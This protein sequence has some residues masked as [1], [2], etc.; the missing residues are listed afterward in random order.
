MDALQD[1]FTGLSPHNNDTVYRCI[2]DTLLLKVEHNPDS[3]PVEWIFNG[4]S[5]PFPELSFLLPQ[6]DTLTVQYVMNHDFCPDTTTTFIV[7]LP[8]P[9]FTYCHDD[10]LCHGASLSVEQPNVISSL[11]ST[12][13][14]TPAITVDSAGV[15]SV[16]VTNRGCRAESDLFTIDL[17]PQSAVAFGNDSTLCELAT[18]LLDATQPHPASYEWQDQSTNT[19]YT[20]FEDGQY[21]VVVT[22]HCLGASDTIAIGYLTDFTVDL[23]PDTTL[24]EGRTLLLSAEVPFCNYE[25]QN[26]SDRPTF[27]V[28]HPGTYSVTVTNKCFIHGDD[29]VVEYEPCE[30]ELWLP[31]SFT[32]DGD[33]LN[34]VFLPIFAYPDEV[35]S[36]EMTIFD[37]WGMVQY[38]TRRVD[39]GWD[40]AGVPDGVYVVLVRYK[41]RGHAP[42]SVTGNVVKLGN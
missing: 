21:W 9:M 3:V 2:G 1:C 8:P 37:R 15:Y 19:T 20:V 41:T 14:H 23:G 28:Q 13:A 42:Q 25:W 34:D 24:C 31:N 39:Q 7:V 38:S 10:T 12:S 18:L 27:L 5:Y 16:T 4:E 26:G 40:G 36:Y 33:G 29:I 30:Q 32:P 11:W 17:Y 35:E 6:V 22:D